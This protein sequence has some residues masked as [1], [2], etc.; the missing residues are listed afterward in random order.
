MAAMWLRLWKLTPAPLR[1][2]AH[3]CSQR[4]SRALLPVWFIFVWRRG[5]KARP[6]AG[7][8]IQGLLRSA[9]GIG[10]GGRLFVDALDRIGIS[11]LQVD[12][13]GWASV[14]A[15]LDDEGRGDSQ[16]FADVVV[17]HLNPP[18][19]ERVVE[20]SWARAQRNR[21]HVGYWAWELPEAPQSWRRG[22]RFVDEVWA[23]SSFTADALRRIA[24]ADVP[25]H[26]TPHP[27][28]ASPAG[29]A[30]RSHFYLPEDACIV[31]TALDLRST[32]AR[33]NP[34]GAL[35]A[36][37]AAA[38]NAAEPSVL[39]CKVSG[40]AMEPELFARLR[41]D[42]EA[43]SDIRLVEQVLA[44]RDMSSLV[45]SADIILSP[46]RAEG[47]GLLLAEGMRLGKA[48]V[49]TGWSGNMDFMD[50]TCAALIDYSLTPAVD[51]QGLYAGACW[52]EPDLDHAATLLASLISSRD[53]R[54]ALGERAAARGGPVFDPAA[55]ATLIKTRL[56]AIR[57]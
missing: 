39:V 14:Y 57:R 21:R 1:A 30:D 2:S 32:S 4:L 10:Q 42:C 55:W 22:F 5:A 16:A 23:P 34:M 20:K 15:D 44:P 31:L 28:W 13:G 52:A 53:A 46:H 17:S 45:A 38:A 7:V 47:F 19:L 43:R 26:V 49:A 40:A 24:S 6:G 33:K 51:L 9:I 18:E 25:V 36:Y 3:R 27:V 29:A 54:L 37:K 12:A 50:Q 41:A 8:A 48:V 35:A 11:V 56:E